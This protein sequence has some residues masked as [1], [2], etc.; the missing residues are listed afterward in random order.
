[1]CGIVGVAGAQAADDT[2]HVDRMLELLV[3]RGPDSSGIDRLDGCVLGHRRLSIVDLDHGEQPLTNERGTISVVANG[4]IYNHE[5]VRQRLT[6]HEWAT[7][8]DCEAIVHLYEEHGLD[9]LDHLRGMFA[10]ALWDADRSRL[11]LAKDRFGKKPLYWCERAGRLIFASELASLVEHPLVETEPDHAALDL[12]FGLQYI[13]P[14]LTA[15]RSVFSLEPGHVLTFER[16][17]VQVRRYWEPPFDR[18]N[19]V[20][21]FPEAVERVRSAVD[22]AV[23][24]RLMSDVPL[25]AFLSGGIDSSVVVSSMARQTSG[26]VKTFSIGFDEAGF[27]ER[28]YARMVAAKW[29]TDHHEFVVRPNA[30]EVLPTIVEHHGQ[31]FADSSALPTHYVSELTRSGVT[32]AL[33]GDGGDEVFGGYDRYSAA[34]LADLVRPLPIGPAV[35]VIGAAARLVPPLQR[36]AGRLER[37]AATRQLSTLSAY[38]R[39][40]AHFTPERKHWLYTDEMRNA[41]R[42]E[43]HEEWLIGVA[44]GM[45]G[46]DT[47]NRLSRLDMLTYLPDDVLTKVDIASMTH[48]LEVRCPLLD[49]EVAD[50]VAPMHSSWKATLRHRKRLLRAAFADDIP[51]AILKRSKRGFG[52]PVAEWFRGSLGEHARDLICRGDAASRRYVRTSSVTTLLDEHRAGSA[53]NGPLLWNLVIFEMWLARFVERNI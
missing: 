25:G 20:V 17:A 46:L 10:I 47:V 51:P 35:R 44:N 29:G 42:P 24:V 36:F 48:S 4:E 12:Y 7:G 6:H 15:Y 22:E 23:R 52:V 50:L 27:D 3:H 9:F 41:V 28:P 19:T 1:M 49:Q 21:S 11:V 13:P 33:S 18:R 39:W 14:P 34:L 16:G 5:S 45:P 40:M 8:S 37:F 2:A 30:V 26:P 31:P 43:Q 32:V 38:S 53:D